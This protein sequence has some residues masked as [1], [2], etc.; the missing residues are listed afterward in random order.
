MKKT[1][2]GTNVAGV[3]SALPFLAA[4][5]ALGG[6]PSGCGGSNGSNATDGNTTRLVASWRLVKTSGGLDGNGYAVPPGGETRTFFQN[7]TFTRMVS[8]QT[9][10]G[11]YQVTRRKTFLNEGELPVVTYSTIA[12][13]D[14]IFQLDSQHLVI[15]EEATDGFRREYERVSV[16]P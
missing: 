8:G 3:L 7:G 13:P 1:I 4:L 10:S 6:V 2:R 5:V 14:I 16:N 11:T 15:T 12:L 9:T